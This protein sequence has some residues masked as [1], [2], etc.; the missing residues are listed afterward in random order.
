MLI[1]GQ[2][3][4]WSVYCSREQYLNPLQKRSHNGLPSG[5]SHVD[6]HEEFE[7]QMFGRSIDRYAFVSDEAV[8]VETFVYNVMEQ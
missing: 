4:L 2:R 1:L 7:C 5:V 8:F 3:M 6:Y